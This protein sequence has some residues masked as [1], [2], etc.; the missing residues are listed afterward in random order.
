MFDNVHLHQSTKFRVLWPISRN[1]TSD[2]TVHGTMSNFLIST[3][4]S[5]VLHVCGQYCSVYH[6][7]WMEIEG[8]GGGRGGETI[9]Q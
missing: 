1:I 4:I 3:T 8:R 2:M 6:N 5:F 9:N 7:L